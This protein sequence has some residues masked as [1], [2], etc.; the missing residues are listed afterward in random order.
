PG[1][2]PPA[3][4]SCLDRP[5]GSA[6]VPP[7]AARNVRADEEETGRHALPTA[8]PRPKRASI[9]LA[10]ALSALWLFFS[11]RGDWS[12]VT[13]PRLGVP[14]TPITPIAPAA[15]AEDT[16]PEPPD[17]FAPG[18]KGARVMAATPKE[19]PAS[20]IP[21]V[22]VVPGGAAPEAPAVTGP[23]SREN[24]RGTFTPS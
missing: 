4:G 8:D 15:M 10:V 3:G 2:A 7:E 18:P 21:G 20:A 9:A 12:L 16:M 14:S 1:A 11:A 23:D 24:A 19:E 5:S 6:P 22:A 13:R 17:L